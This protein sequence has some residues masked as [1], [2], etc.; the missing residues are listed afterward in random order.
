MN[1]RVR[2]FAKNALISPVC[3]DKWDL[4][5]VVCTQPFNKHVK[6]G[7]SF[8]KV[9]CVDEAPVN[10]T[11][12]KANYLSSATM[13]GR[14]KVRE[15]SPDS[16]LDDGKPSSTLFSKWREEKLSPTKE[17]G[18][19]NTAN[20]SAAAAIREASNK[21]ST[22]N[23]SPEVAKVDPEQSCSVKKK[24]G[25]KDIDE[26]CPPDRNRHDLMYDEEDDTKSIPQLEM[27]I[28]RDRDRIEKEQKGM[29]AKNSKPSGSRDSSKK[30]GASTTK[31]REFADADLTPGRG[32]ISLP[33][34]RADTPR[35]EK[36]LNG[37]PLQSKKADL[38]VE[39]PPSSSKKRPSSP[40]QQDKPIAKKKMTPVKKVTY[41][42]YSKLLEGVVLV[43]S[44][45][46]ASF[47]R[48]NH[49]QIFLN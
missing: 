38:K 42:P 11:G 19:T 41:K 6:Y 20:L 14:F 24:R 49:I 44:G 37:G 32:N 22:T 12:Q 15:D 28:I 36:R 48:T 46:Q 21:L 35:S 18:G 8:V 7:L 9:H 30:M 39:T 5:K 47:S 2:C 13:F 29:Q 25:T 31:F 10:P 34:A 23:Y 26:K 16:D 17:S 27:K 1:N 3:D 40:M 4:I 33:K 43:I 45:I